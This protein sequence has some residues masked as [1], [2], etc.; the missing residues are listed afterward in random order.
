MKKSKTIFYAALNADGTFT[1][2]SVKGRYSNNMK[3]YE[4]P[5]A[6][7]TNNI[8]VVYEDEFGQVLDVIDS[9]RPIA[10]GESALEALHGL[11][12][13]IDA[14]ESKIEQRLKFLRKAN[15]TAYKRWKTLFGEGFPDTASAV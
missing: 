3:A 1:E 7:A 9:T 10:F 13:T 15:G 4:I 8:S 5:N 6:V 2:G 14:L 12:R 11:L